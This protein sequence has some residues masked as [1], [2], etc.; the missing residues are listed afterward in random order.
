MN[1]RLRA[2]LI[3]VMGCKPFVDWNIRGS[4]NPVGWKRDSAVQMRGRTFCPTITHTSSM[5]SW[6]TQGLMRKKEMSGV[7]TLWDHIFPEEGG[8]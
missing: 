4:L 3:I 7:C 6:L 8:W 1:H 5:N 2:N